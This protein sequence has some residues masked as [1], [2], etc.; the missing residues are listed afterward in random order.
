M[1]R[2][3]KRVR[4]GWTAHGQRAGPGS[5]YRRMRVVALSDHPSLLLR[6]AQQGRVAAADAERLRFEAE[7]ARHRGRLKRAVRARDQARAQHRWWAW[8][9][10]S[11]AVRRERRL[12]PAE[13][14]PRQP[15]SDREAIA[16]AGIEG[17]QLV[18]RR[19]GDKLGDDWVLL[20]GYRN[21][22]GEIDH[23]LLGPRGLFAIEGKHRNATVHCA[24]DRW[25]Y[26]KYDKYNNPVERG[27]MADKTGRSPSQQLNEPAD[28]LEGF[29]RSRGHPIRIQRVV[30]LTHDRSRIGSCTN[31]TAHVAT[32]TTE[33]TKLI[34]R[35]KASIADDERATLE[36][37]IVGDHDHYRA[38]RTGPR[39][40]ARS[41]RRTGNRPRA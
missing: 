24:G 31:P 19:L 34:R 36:R 1:S 13:P 28:Q 41:S 7:L 29:L 16:T 18:E 23:L 33:V 27:E 35:S 9:T 2:R 4:Y 25:W 6:E 10:G 39:T 40:R 8:L 11:L 22:R 3:R 37:L 30:L 32:S 26:I 38:R 21:N 15:R 17:E 14:R 12:T 5:I 20:R